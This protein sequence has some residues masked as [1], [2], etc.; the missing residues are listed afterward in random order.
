LLAAGGGSAGG[1]VVELAAEFSFGA[2]TLV[3]D[4]VDVT[5]VVEGADTT[6]STVESP[7]ADT[8]LAGSAFCIST[9]VVNCWLTALVTAGLKLTRYLIAYAV[10]YPSH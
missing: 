4:V 8:T 9:V 1:L 3:G 10:L 7:V 6:E 2:V 5:E